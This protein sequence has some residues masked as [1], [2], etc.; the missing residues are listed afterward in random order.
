MYNHL[1]ANVL[2]QYQSPGD[3][4]DAK[5]LSIQAC[6]TKSCLTRH[7][8]IDHQNQWQGSKKLQGDPKNAVSNETVHLS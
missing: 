8:S 1:S 6:F 7:G 5:L 2:A 4:S 3:S